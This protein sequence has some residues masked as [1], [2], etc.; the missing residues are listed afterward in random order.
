MWD[1]SFMSDCVNSIAIDGPAASGKSTIAL[2][3]AQELGYHFFDTG[4]M[5]RA[6]TW[7]ALDQGI[8]ITDEAAVTHLA[9]TLD[10]D[11]RPPT[12]D[13]GRTVDVIINGKDVTWNMREPQVDANVS[14]VAAYPE[15]RKELGERQKEIGQRGQ[16]VMVGRDI[17]TVV[18]PNACLKIFL[19]ASTEER[20]R[21]RYAEAQDWGES[22]DF[23]QVLAHLIERDRIDTTREVAPLIVAEDAEII[24]SDG[25]TVGEVLAAC[26]ALVHKNF[27]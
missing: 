7:A 18:L 25:M 6:V 24:N 19:D 1:N 22:S 3:L 23:E 9:E 27:T 14:N 2:L 8:P 12:V 11:Q 13:D 10:L 26:L 20:A 17:G 5:Y 16:V 4:L 21:R 15:V